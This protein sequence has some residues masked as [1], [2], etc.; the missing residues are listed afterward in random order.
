LELETFKNADHISKEVHDNVIR[1]MK[2]EQEAEKAALLEEIKLLKKPKINPM[3]ALL[4]ESMKKKIFEL[5]ASL[6]VA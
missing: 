5:E 2:E 4:A 3:E 6:R 1:M